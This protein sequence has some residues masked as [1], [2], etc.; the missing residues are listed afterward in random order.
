MLKGA[1]PPAPATRVAVATRGTGGTIPTV[2]LVPS[3]YL[4]TLFT[5]V[6]RLL[7]DAKGRISVQ[8]R[9]ERPKITPAPA[10]TRRGARGDVASP[11]RFMAGTKNSPVGQMPTEKGR[12]SSSAPPPFTTMPSLSAQQRSHRTR[13]YCRPRFAGLV[14][15]SRS[16]PPRPGLLHRAGRPGRLLFGPRRAEQRHHLTVALL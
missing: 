16:A 15:I 11:Q 12:F 14:R 6:P 10:L 4:S 7:D 8:I 3:A 1:S 5:G 9:I 2:G 13:A